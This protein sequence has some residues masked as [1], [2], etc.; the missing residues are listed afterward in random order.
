MKAEQI[1]DALNWLDDSIIDE[2]NRI[3]KKQHLSDRQT[4][5]KI[6]V[7]A[8]A[9]MGIMCI[10]YTVKLDGV[11]RQ[12][13]P[14][15][16]LSTSS[17]AMGFEARNDI[18]EMDNGN[19]WNEDM[20]LEKLPVYHN[21]A[22][23]PTG[24]PLGLGE[25]SIKESAETTAKALHMKIIAISDTVA[26]EWMTDVEPG[27]VLSTT[28]TAVNKENTLEAEILAEADGHVR[29][30]FTGEMLL[31]Q[32]YLQDEKKLT[33]ILGYI[34]P[35]KYERQNE[36]NFYD[37]SGDEISDILNYNFNHTTFIMNDEGDSIKMIHK[38]EELSCAEKI[39]DYPIIT[40]E[41]A[42]KLLLKGKYLEFPYELPGEKYIAGV[43]LVYRTG[44]LEKTF[45]PYYRFWVE[46]P[47]LQQDNELKCYGAYYVPAV[48][49]KYISNPIR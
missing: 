5:W 10:L 7:A 21:N 35:E 33:E 26:K 34:K 17:D 30:E 46:L 25:A 18:S 32:T 29:I 31:A 19:P 2:A 49:E 47:E 6:I 13:L 14:M 9:C 16:E 38:C 48:E 45:M 43:E 3:R 12:E 23:H 8:C 27:T 22:Y 39:G 15:L 42:K 4:K 41:K 40:A 36:L 11:T 28:A 37:G 1:S 44:R 24:V 20:E